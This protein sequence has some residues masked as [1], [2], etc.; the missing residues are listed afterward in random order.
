[1]NARTLLI[2][3]T[4]LI[5]SLVVLS[6]AP[7][8]SAQSF[9]ERLKNAA[10]K[11]EQ[12]VK[13]EVAPK[14]LPEKSGN[15]SSLDSELQKRHDAMVGP[16]NN[17]NA[18]DEA[19]TVRLPETHTA[20]FAPLGYPVEATYGIKSVKPVMPPREAS[21]QVNWSEKQPNVYELDNQSLVAEFLMLDDCFADGYIKTLTPAH[22]RYDEIVKGELWARVGALN[23]MVE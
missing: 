22:W 11:I 10:K 12:K 4:L 8:A 20:L 3:R 14:K 23:K 5:L 21:D 6:G 7:C 9:K 2:P 17:K 15:T 13:Q 19:P 18:E 16:D 1:M